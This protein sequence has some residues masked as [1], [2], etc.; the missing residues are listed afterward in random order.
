MHGTGKPL[1]RYSEVV[2][3]DAQRA[4]RQVADALQQAAR[5]L[6]LG[7]RGADGDVAGSS[8]GLALALQEQGK[9]VTVYNEEPYGDGVD[10]LPAADAVVTS[11]PPDAHFDVTV[12]VDAADPQR[13][14]ADFPPV[15]RRGT[16]IWVDHHR[17]DEPPGDVNYIDLT[18][19]AVG[20]QIAT[21]LDAM[22]HPLSR[23]V[24]ICLY[25]S[26]M[27]DTGGFRYANTSARALRLAGRLVAAGVQ[28]WEIT[29]HL[30]E[31][32][33]E[34]KIRLLARALSSLEMSRNGK[35]GL[36]SVSERD[37]ERSGAGPQHLHGI[38][39]HVRG[40]RGVEIAIMAREVGENV[41]LVLRSSGNVS[42]GEI[43][44]R[45]GAHGN[46][47]AAR[48]E[49]PMGLHEAEERV[50]RI[51]AEVA[52]EPPAN[53]DVS[54]RPP[55]SARNKKKNRSRTRTALS[56]PQNV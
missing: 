15:S 47:N 23:E 7:H 36:V 19:A 11:L 29:Q 45:L 13:C 41:E 4:A 39:N 51:A 10:W 28:P 3:E 30:Y 33:P 22:G 53:D 44:A 31:S 2:P 27:S 14:G 54:A 25:T 49:L 20:E 34:P 9:A 26:L 8:L 18:A 50:L 5:V 56:S 24:A 42:A 35:V 55:L 6:V 32:Q 21:I 16:F 38:V 17:I 48:F 1:G 52:G 12:V 40:I 37:L 46:P 43:A